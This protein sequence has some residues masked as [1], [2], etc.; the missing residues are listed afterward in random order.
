MLNMKTA[1]ALLLL[2]SLTSAAQQPRSGAPEKHIGTATRLVVLFDG[3]ER[4][5]IA[6]E[7][8]GDEAALDQL[9]AG[10]FEVWTPAPPGEP[11]PRAEWLA[12]NKKRRPADS[13]SLRQMA[14]RDLRDHAAA[15][16][17]LLETRG[18]AQTACFVVDVWAREGN[19]GWKLTDR[20]I[21]PVNPA[22]YAGERKP[23]G[24]E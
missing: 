14:V 9:L 13:F 4:R 7:Q 8:H 5:L 15:S 11:I 1:A 2:V 10:D 6:A 19:G 17:V 16:Y 3:L 22:S 23:T 18:T 20:Y 24:K 21:A 12:Q